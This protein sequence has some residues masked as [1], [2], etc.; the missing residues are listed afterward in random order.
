MKF[1]AE[2]I[3]ELRDAERLTAVRRIEI[4]LFGSFACAGL[5]PMPSLR[6]TTPEPTTASAPIF[7]AI[8][9]PN[10]ETRADAAASTTISGRTAITIISGNR[11]RGD[12]AARRE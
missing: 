10:M 11:V 9:T 8:G 6:A 2:F 7:S 5:R 3:S 1:A 12:D 4:T